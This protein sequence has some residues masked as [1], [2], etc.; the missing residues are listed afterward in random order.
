VF[1]SSTYE[2]LIEERQEVMHALLELDCFPA[3]MELFPAA[4]EDQW[5]TIKNVIDY[6]D[7]YIVIIGGRY[8]SEDSSGMSYT[9]KEYRYA[10]EKSKP[11]IAFLYENPDNLPVNKTDK[12]DEKRTKLN[13]FKNYVSNKMFKTWTNAKDLGS[14][15]SR[16]LIKLI[17]QNPAIGWV[18]ADRIPSED[19]TAELLKL[20]KKIDELEEELERERRDPPEGIEKYAQGDQYFEIKYN[21]DSYNNKSNKY[22][23]WNSHLNVTWN[24]IFSHIS[25]SMLNENSEFDLKNRLNDYIVE[26]EYAITSNNHKNVRY[27]KITIESFDLII[28]QIFALGLIKKSMEKH[29]PSDTNKYWSLTEYGEQTMMRLKALKNVKYFEGDLPDI[30]REVIIAFQEEIDDAIIELPKLTYDNN[31]YV[32]KDHVIHLNIYNKSIY[33]IPETIENLKFMETL[34]IHYCKIDT[35]PSSI[36]K[37]SKLQT[38]SLLNNDIKFI[39]ENIGDLKN[40]K[41]LNL[42]YNN[43]KR[44]PDTIGGLTNLEILDLSHNP[45]EYLPE[46]LKELENLIELSC[47]FTNIDSFP[48]GITYLNNI[49]RL[50]IDGNFKNIPDSLFDLKNL[51]Y[52]SISCEELEEIPSLIRKFENLSELNI[53]CRNLSELPTEIGELSNLQELNIS[54]CSLKTIPESILDLKN[55]KILYIFENLIQPLSDQIEKVLKELEMQGCQVERD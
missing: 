51:D 13:E 15:V 7:Y 22:E 27:F 40:L 23:T 30:E 55:L 54:E 14:V 49:N 25:A 31:G 5:T 18:R 50:S 9:E 33:L 29:T 19:V 6:C 44:I 12:N 45:I 17:K 10:L 35:I 36:T 20:R 53:Y 41:K 32:G 47:G 48:I 43:I 24:K 34:N 8:G 28:I 1:V 11:I 42:A 2:D 21:F 38:L 52:L 3:G 4:N 39:P 37:L 46:S 16:S 26:K